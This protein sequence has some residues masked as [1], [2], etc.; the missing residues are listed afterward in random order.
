MRWFRKSERVHTVTDKIQ[1]ERN[2]QFQRP[3]CPVN[4]GMAECA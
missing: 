1:I 4:Q 3:K 2:Q